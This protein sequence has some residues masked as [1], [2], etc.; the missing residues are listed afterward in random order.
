MNDNLYKD[1]NIL[2]KNHLLVGMFSE[3]LTLNRLLN[4]NKTVNNL[5]N[6]IEN[7]DPNSFFKNKKL[8]DEIQKNFITNS[9]DP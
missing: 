1:Y 7:H 3:I 8:K 2:K 5:V 4:S 9:I 6:E